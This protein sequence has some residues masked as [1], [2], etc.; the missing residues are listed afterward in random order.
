MFNRIVWFDL[1]ASDLER[2]MKFYSRVLGAE[3]NERFSGVGVIS[4]DDGAVSGCVFKSE[5]IRPSD[6]GVL[7]YF[8][9]DGRLE[10]AVS[11]AEECGGTVYEAP[12]AIGEFGHRAIVID[13]EGNRIALHSS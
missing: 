7:L 2:A 11:V 6:Q 12:H 8:N 9:V 1:P 10:E 5:E 3:V 13:S 4:S